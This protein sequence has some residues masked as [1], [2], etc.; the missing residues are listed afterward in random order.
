MR[1]VLRTLQSAPRPSLLPPTFLLPMLS[2]EQ[3]AAFSNTSS[4]AQR[5]DR[6]PDRGVSALRRTGLRKRQ[7]VSVKAEN[8]PKPVLDPARRSKVQTDP[9]H[10]LWQFFN[11]EKTPFATPDFDNAHGRAWTVQE[12]RRKDWEDLHKLWWR[13]IK[14][15]NRLSTEAY[16]RKRVEAGYGDYES[17]GRDKEVRTRRFPTCDRGPIRPKMSMWALVTD[18]QRRSDSQCGQSNTSLQSV[19]MLGRM[20]VNLPKEILGSTCKRTL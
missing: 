15:R 5:R 11:P 7:T 12:L 6:N 2:I 16:E 9:E 17:E 10:G 13:C 4:I 20:H 14:E 1:L 19:G 18:S 8:L 3:T